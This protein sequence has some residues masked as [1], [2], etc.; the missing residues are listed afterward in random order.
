MIVTRP[1]PGSIIEIEVTN[2]FAARMLPPQPTCTVYR[3]Q[4]LKSY[5]W[6]TDREFCMQGD[7]KWPIRVINLAN[8]IRIQF[9]SGSGQAVDT[10]SKSWEVT[11]SRGNRYL[12][13]RDTSGWSCDC[14]GFQFRKNCRH[15]TEI[16]QQ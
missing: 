13:T 16:E 4:V 2:P 10:S 15:I 7:A 11:G 3:G 12:V 14:K 5:R 9:E 8:V 6:L 1:Q